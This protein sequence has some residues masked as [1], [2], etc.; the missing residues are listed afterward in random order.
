MLEMLEHFS[1]KKHIEYEVIVISLIC[2][3]TD[4]LDQYIKI[5]KERKYP[6]R[7]TIIRAVVLRMDNDDCN[8]SFWKKTYG[9]GNL[10]ALHKA[11]EDGNINE[12]E[13]LI[14]E[15]PFMYRTMIAF[16]PMPHSEPEDGPLNKIIK[17]E[18]ISSQDKIKICKMFIK[19]A[20]TW[21]LPNFVGTWRAD[22][23]QNCLKCADV[24]LVKFLLENSGSGDGF[25]IIHAFRS[26]GA[27]VASADN[28]GV[29]DL[30]LSSIDGNIPKYV[31]TIMAIDQE[32]FCDCDF[33]AVYRFIAV[34]MFARKRD[35]A[36]L[37]HVLAN[38]NYVQVPLHFSEL[39]V[40]E[41]LLKWISIQEYMK[42]KSVRTLR[43]EVSFPESKQHCNPKY[44]FTDPKNPDLY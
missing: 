40:E 9:E 4:G 41:S 35:M 17:N 12:I 24:H 2:A 10:F 31:R 20:G 5:T 21:Q 37:L 18:N 32:S 39:I 44:D 16:N 30:M 7:E 29:F 22:I 23:L 14:K 6:I 27:V 15:S 36:L 19:D 26:L 42:P 8:D 1:V 13:R 3:L 34:F 28:V 11:C 25:D 33:I 38:Q 43:D